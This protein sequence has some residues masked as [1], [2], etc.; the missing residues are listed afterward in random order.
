MVTLDSYSFDT[1]F[2]L[3]QAQLIS[4][5]VLSLAAVDFVRPDG[6]ILLLLGLVYVLHELPYIILEIPNI[7]MRAYLA[8]A[9]FFNALPS[10]VI[11]EPSLT[12]DELCKADR[13][14][15]NCASLLELTIVESVNEL[16]KLL[17][18]IVEAAECLL[19]YP[20]DLAC[21]VGILVSEVW[22]NAIEHGKG[23]YTAGVMQVYGRGKHRRLVL[24][25]GD[26][27]IGIASSLIGNEKFKHIDNDLDAIETAIMPKVSGLLDTT[28]GNGLA[29]VVEKTTKQNGIL[30]IRSG[31]ARLRRQ[32]ERNAHWNH[33]LPKLPGTQIVVSLAAA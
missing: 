1:L 16:P 12:R 9:G 3:W 4:T 15:G 11:V 32:G 7:D 24:A 21:D 30:N 20:S 2:P 18:R 23:K 6:M 31:S 14:N 10:N 27:G 8:R 33:H 13:Y 5:G 17:D 22:Q 28:R 25:I 26:N 29:R 19:H